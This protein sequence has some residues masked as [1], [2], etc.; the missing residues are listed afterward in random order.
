M[1]N[2]TMAQLENTYRYFIGLLDLG[3]IPLYWWNSY[4]MR[5]GLDLTI[6][7]AKQ[8]QLTNVANIPFQLPYNL[9]GIEPNVKF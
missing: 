7:V 2:T 9:I 1:H 4:D 8:R 6:C 3:T 5:T